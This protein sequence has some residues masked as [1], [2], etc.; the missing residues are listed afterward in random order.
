M[1]RKKAV[2]VALL[3]AVVNENV[4]GEVTEAVSLL[5]GAGANP[6]AVSNVDGKECTAL[7]WACRPGGRVLALRDDHG[8]QP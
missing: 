7:A 3:H 8:E 4:R 2:E 5:L 6:N 1:A